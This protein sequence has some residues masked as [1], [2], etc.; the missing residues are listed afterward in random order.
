MNR[1]RAYII[2][3]FA[4]VA[5]LANA[6]GQDIG[7]L[8]TRP[9]KEEK[10]KATN[11][12][13]VRGSQEA[14]LLRNG[15][16]LAGALVGIESNIVTWKHPDASGPVQLRIP[17][18]AELQ[19]K[20]EARSHNDST[21]ACMV[22][23]TNDDQLEGELLS[24]DASQIA[25]KTWYAGELRFPRNLVQSIM[26]TG[27]SRSTIYEGPAGLDGWTLGKTTAELPNQGQWAY[28]NGAFYATKAASIARDVH[29]PDVSSLQFDL[30]W[31]GYFQLA[32][33]L[34]S[35]S[36]QPVSLA[37][38]ESAPDFGG[39]YSLQLNTFSAN[40]LP[41]TKIDPIR[42]L[43]Q[44]SLLTLSQKS[45]AHID[46][47][48]SKARHSITLLVNGELV[49][50]WIDPSEFAGH[51]TAIRF[52]HQ[53]QGAVKIDNIK[54]T[55]WDGLFEDKEA[56]PPPARQD[57][58]KLRNGD[59]ASG[60]VA[61]IQDGVITMNVLDRKLEIPFTR[62]KE[63]AF[64]REHSTHPPAGQIDMRGFFTRGGSLSL[65]VEK[66][67]SQALV[68]TSP[69]FGKATFHPRAFTRLEFIAPIAN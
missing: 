12:P 13:M 56:P 29:L 37:N 5:A 26:P 67:D 50:E 22:R 2:R 68:A 32:I 7:V 35:D 24:L 61:T 18:I 31:K 46:I 34:Y 39:F 60:S 47:R 54:V 62:A 1:A 41:I 6:Y 42:Y 57:L 48:T 44:A 64:A 38:K 40:L 66:W 23:L 11:A 15:D 53:G 69:I 3:V 59:R 21:N 36:L 51:G 4:V 14:A 19:V 55:E 27:P 20:G 63:I 43:G 49:R 25:L 45:R 10:P 17:S 52:V 30:T 33:A 16:I 28:R 9:Q 8:I 65:Q 58:A